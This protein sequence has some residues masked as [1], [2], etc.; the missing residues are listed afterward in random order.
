MTRL[1][2]KVIKQLNIIWDSDYIISTSKDSFSI[3]KIIFCIHLVNFFSELKI[4]S[5]MKIHNIQ[6]QGNT[7][8]VEGE[9]NG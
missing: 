7:L 8:I 5:Y 6:M 4:P 3:G 1:E 2:K 9:T